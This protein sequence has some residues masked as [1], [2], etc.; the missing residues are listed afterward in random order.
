MDILFLMFQPKLITMNYKNQVP[1]LSSVPLIP[2]KP[3]V[4]KELQPNKGIQN[5]EFRGTV[6]PLPAAV[7]HINQRY[8]FDNNGGNYQGL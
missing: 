7:R 5:P 1:K 6:I 4:G 3:T 8:S 2:V